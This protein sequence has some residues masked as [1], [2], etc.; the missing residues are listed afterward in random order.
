[1]SYP[2]LPGDGEYLGKVCSAIRIFMS[3][4]GSRERREVRTCPFCGSQD[5]IYNQ[6]RGTRD[7][8]KCGKC[9]KLFSKGSQGK[10]TENYY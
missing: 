3:G 2:Q 8:V 10:L 6:R 4:Q 1:M 9:G 7:I 5:L